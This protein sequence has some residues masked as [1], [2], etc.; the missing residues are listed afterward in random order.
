[1]HT[2]LLLAYLLAYISIDLLEKPG[3]DDNDLK[4]EAGAMVS[5]DHPNVM[6]ML[7]LCFDAPTLQLVLEV[8][9]M[10]FVCVCIRMC[11]NEY[12]PCILCEYIMFPCVTHSTFSLIIYICIY[13]SLSQS[14]V[15]VV[16]SPWCNQ[17]LSPKER[18]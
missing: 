9:I 6:K 17:L 7:G 16:C 10:V 12:I 5:L 2:F 3:A 11:M 1:M 18:D 15:D 8:G 4:R 14:L 13:I